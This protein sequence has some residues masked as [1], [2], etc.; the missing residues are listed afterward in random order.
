MQAY[1]RQFALLEQKEKAKTEPC[2]PRP[3]GKAGEDTCAETQGPAS[4]KKRKEAEED[5]ANSSRKKPKSTDEDKQPTDS[6]RGTDKDI[7]TEA[8][9]T[10]ASKA[11]GRPPH[12]KLT[13]KQ[14]IGAEK[15]A[16]GTLVALRSYKASH[17][18]PRA[19]RPR[20]EPE[21]K[22]ADTTF[23]IPGQTEYNVVQK[24]LRFAGK[25]SYTWIEAQ[26]AHLAE[27]VPHAAGAPDWLPASRKA[28]LNPGRRM[29]DKKRFPAIK[30]CLAKWTYESHMQE[31]AAAFSAISSKE[32]DSTIA[33]DVTHLKTEDP[34]EPASP[35]DIPEVEMAM[36][37]KDDGTQDFASNA[38]KQESCAD[39]VKIEGAASIKQENP[40][41][42][43]K[44]E[45]GGEDSKGSAS[46][47]SASAAAP[48]SKAE[49][50]IP[51]KEHQH[52]DTDR[53]EADRKKNENGSNASM[54]RSRFGDAPAVGGQRVLGYGSLAITIPVGGSQ[55]A[56]QYGWDQRVRNSDTTSLVK[57]GPGGQDLAGTPDQRWQRGAESPAMWGSKRE[58]TGPPATSLSGPSS[59][60]KIGNSALSSS[61]WDRSIGRDRSEARSSK[62]DADQ[63]ARW[64][65]SK[66]ISPGHVLGKRDSAPPRDGGPPSPTRDST[67]NWARSSREGSGRTSAWDQPPS[68]GETQG[69]GGGLSRDASMA[70][71]DTDRSSSAIRN[72]ADISHDLRRDSSPLPLRRRVSTPPRGIYEMRDRGMDMSVGPVGGAGGGGLSRESLRRERED[73]LLRD[74]EPAERDPPPRFMRSEIVRSEIRSSAPERANDSPRSRGMLN[75]WDVGPRARSPRPLDRS[76]SLSLC[77]SLCLF[78]LSHILVYLFCLPCIIACVQ[79]MVWRIGGIWRKVSIYGEKG[80]MRVR[81]LICLW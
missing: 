29:I 19:V 12:Q 34:R 63:D 69:E 65:R 46:K 14:K 59:P 48:S 67:G 21:V 50:R 3:Q 66:D 49:I 8:K 64:Q 33:L 7:A 10:P 44:A 17:D 72:L 57:N 2:T 11:R 6:P 75:Q 24:C 68:Q 36:G 25:K 41:E 56:S 55:H 37:G 45:R 40:Q 80:V 54:E 71:R 15:E 58:G 79:F 31:K 35:D 61:S 26:L 60:S 4:Q 23:P 47:S 70:D 51:R 16:T 77:L 43:V 38:I 27:H 28:R 78:A 81:P 1:M 22:L 42:D 9:P 13:G 73:A 32:S 53:P 52:V 5:D 30:S 74:R 39:F 20:R 62:S 18:A 76:L